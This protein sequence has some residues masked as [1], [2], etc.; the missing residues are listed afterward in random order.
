MKR[1][2]PLIIE[3]S[4]ES[5]FGFFPD[6]PGLA[7][8]GETREDVVVHAHKYLR[9]YLSDYKQR[10]EP[11]PKATRAVGLELMEVDEAEVKAVAAKAEVR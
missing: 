3:Q 8:S 5:L 4:E 11:W 6:L 7:V 2:Y 9:D 1:T 10:G